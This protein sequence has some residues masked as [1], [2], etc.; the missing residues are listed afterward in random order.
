MYQCTPHDRIQEN[1][2]LEILG[3]L[4]G[5]KLFPDM[6]RNKFRIMHDFTFER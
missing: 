3:Y 4:P 1:E 5:Q 6:L 2:A